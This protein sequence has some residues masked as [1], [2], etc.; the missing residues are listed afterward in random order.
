MNVLKFIAVTTEKEALKLYEEV[1]KLMKKGLSKN[2]ALNAL[3]KDLKS[4]SR[5]ENIYVLK[6][7]RPVMY[8]KVCVYTERYV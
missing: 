4:F 1:K 2:K 6:K 8:E 7:M 3:K 5:V